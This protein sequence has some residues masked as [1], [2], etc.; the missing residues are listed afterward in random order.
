MSIVRNLLRHAE[1]EAVLLLDFIR[2][3]YNFLEYFSQ[4]NATSLASIRRLVFIDHLGDRGDV[5]R[6]KFLGPSS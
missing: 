5:L 2:V 1:K 6:V 3:R 4:L